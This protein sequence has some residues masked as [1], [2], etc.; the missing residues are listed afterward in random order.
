M[1]V[2]FEGRITGILR[3]EEADEQRLGLL[4]TGGAEHA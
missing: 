2:L 4:M 1:A 3:A